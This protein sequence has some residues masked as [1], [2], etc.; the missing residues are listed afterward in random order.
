MLLDFLCFEC[1]QGVRECGVNDLRASGL[2][3]DE[4]VCKN[5]N[6][7]IGGANGVNQVQL[8]IFHIFECF[9]S[10]LKHYQNKRKP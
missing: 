5:L 6:V 8:G 7:L 1:L 4:Y 10:I 3:C 2:T 9:G